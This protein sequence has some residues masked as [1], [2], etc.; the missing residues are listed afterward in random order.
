MF[1]AVLFIILAICSGTLLTFWFDRSAPFPA[2][3]CMGAVIGVAIASMA[4]YLL[5]CQLGLGAACMWITVLVLLLP[6][7]LLTRAEFRR[8]AGDTCARAI[9]A[10]TTAIRRPSRK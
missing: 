3:L 8:Q 9:R 2:R 6:G 7:I 10:M 4:G 1:L 5:A